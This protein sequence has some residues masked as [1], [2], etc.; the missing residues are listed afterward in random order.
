MGI[1]SRASS[2]VYPRAVRFLPVI[3]CLCIA[4]ACVAA[5][6]GAEDDIR[7]QVAQWLEDLKSD[8]YQVRETARTSLKQK[9][10]RARDLLEAARKDGDAEVRR[11]VEQ[12]LRRAGRNTTAAADVPPGDLGALG[13]VA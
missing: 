3:V 10:L 11:T 8:A 9:G 12:I 6:L 7:T 4:L 5:P 2:G 1:G 13:L